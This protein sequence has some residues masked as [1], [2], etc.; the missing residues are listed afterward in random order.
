[1][2]EARKGVFED[3]IFDVYILRSSRIHLYEFS[4]NANELLTPSVVYARTKKIT[5][6]SQFVPSLARDKVMI[7]GPQ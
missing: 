6:T 2:L 5:S 4:R 1:M 3:K 7:I